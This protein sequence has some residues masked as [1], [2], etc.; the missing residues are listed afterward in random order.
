M[1]EPMRWRTAAVHAKEERWSSL[2]LSAAAVKGSII[3]NSFASKSTNKIRRAE[4][5]QTPPRHRRR[6]NGGLRHLCPTPTLKA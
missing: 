1:T 6:R 3:P 4:E 2:S 5:K